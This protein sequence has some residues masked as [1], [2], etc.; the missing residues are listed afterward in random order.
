MVVIVALASLWLKN[1]KVDISIILIIQAE[2]DRDIQRE[3]EREEGIVSSLV[4]NMSSANDVQR[5]VHVEALKL[6]KAGVGS[7]WLEPGTNAPSS[8]THTV[9]CR[10]QRS[11]QWPHRMVVGWIRSGKGLSRPWVKMAWK[12]KNIIGTQSARKPS[13]RTTGMYGDG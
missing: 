3:R 4:V 1:D 10:H 13:S 11:L 9:Q 5:S 2:T 12:E 8:F 6:P 7:V